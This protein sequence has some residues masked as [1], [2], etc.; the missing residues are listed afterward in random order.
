MKRDL[1]A[2]V[3]ARIIAEQEAGAEPW[4]KHWSAT[5]GANVPCNA[6][7]NRPYSGCN[8]T[9]GPFSPPAARCLLARGANGCRGV[10]EDSRHQHAPMFDIHPV[11]GASIEIF[12]ADR[13]LETFGRGGAGL[14][15]HVR[16][17]SFA[18]VRKQPRGLQGVQKQNTASNTQ[19]TL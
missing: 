16:R 13:T 11:T 17:R 6:V 3:S 1:Y 8:L 19:N 12:F 9:S 4:I 5:P 10:S 15:W 14:F 18:P 2:E 7:G